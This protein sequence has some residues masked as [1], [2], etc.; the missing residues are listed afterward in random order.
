MCYHTVP[1][2]QNSC[3]CDLEY[4]KKPPQ[5]SHAMLTRVYTYVHHT[6]HDIIISW[7][8][9]SLQLI[10]WI[11]SLYVVSPSTNTQTPSTTRWVVDRELWRRIWSRWSWWSWARGV[12]WFPCG[13]CWAWMPSWRSPVTRSWWWSRSKDLVEY[14]PPNF[15]IMSRVGLYAV[16]NISGFGRQQGSDIVSVAAICA[17]TVNFKYLDE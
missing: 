2:R 16:V 6:P 5:K 7:T 4:I 8:H 3:K 11:H 10:I 9:T 1:F 12:R 17:T 15:N 13:G 14:Q